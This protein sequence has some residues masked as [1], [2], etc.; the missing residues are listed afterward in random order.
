MFDLLNQPVLADDGGALIGVIVLIVAFIGWVM[1][2]IS[3]KNVEQQFRNRRTDPTDPSEQRNE[4]LEEDVE[5]FLEEVNQR[6]QPARRRS[7]RRQEPAEDILEI[8]DEDPERLGSGVREHL[9]EYMAPHRIDQSVQEHMSHS[10]TLGTGVK[11]SV[12][13]HFGRKQKP[14]VKPVIPIQV[15]LA[16]GDS[17]NRTDVLAMLTNPETVKQAI[18]VNEILSPPKSR[19]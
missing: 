3:S 8:V 6:R 5:L 18:L 4:Y 17:R 2:F 14:E 13:S 1:N 16:A 10:R 7:Q 9:S 15:A 11:K 19:R 12:D